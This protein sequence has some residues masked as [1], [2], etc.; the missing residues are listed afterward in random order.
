M[1]V[2]EPIKPVQDEL[3]RSVNVTSVELDFRSWQRDVCGIHY[4]SIRYQTWGDSAWTEVNNNVNW[5]TVRME[6][7]R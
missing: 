2:T 1:P 4:F 6:C 7:S 5:N 3:L